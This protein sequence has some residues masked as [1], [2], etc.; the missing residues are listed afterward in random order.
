MVCRCSPR[1]T[2]PR[3]GVTPLPFPLTTPGA[4][5]AGAQACRLG[6]AAGPES[7]PGPAAWELRQWVV[8]VWSAPV[9]VPKSDWTLT[10]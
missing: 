4:R 10:R 3:H 7:S 6:S 9:K 8:N 5:A 2:Y 1:G